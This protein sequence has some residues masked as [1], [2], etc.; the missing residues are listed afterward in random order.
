MS[1]VS[2]K[3]R[4]PSLNANGHRRRA[5]E[6]REVG[7][8]MAKLLNLTHVTDVLAAVGNPVLLLSPPQG[9]AVF[10]DRRRQLR[11]FPVSQIM[12]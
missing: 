9:R 5:A 7:Q 11:C 2:L 12:I 1:D 4:R 6:I 8:A 3:W 10:V